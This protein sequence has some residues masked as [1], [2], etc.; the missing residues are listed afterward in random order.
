MVEPTKARYLACAARVR[1]RCH[2]AQLLR[3]GDVPELDRT[4]AESDPDVGPVPA[5]IDTGDVRV[6]GSVPKMGDD[7]CV[8]SPEVGAFAECDADEI[9]CA[10]RDEVEVKVVDHAWCVEDAFGGGRD[11]SRLGGGGAVG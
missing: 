11:A 6:V 1:A 9:E 4:C 8:G 5:E 7:A 2:R 3:R 10:P